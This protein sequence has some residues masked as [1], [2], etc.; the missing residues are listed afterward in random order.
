MW[1]ANILLKIFASIFLRDIGI[2]LLL[3]FEIG[4][5]KQRFEWGFDR[6]NNVSYEWAKLLGGP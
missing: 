1:L 5:T 3:N 6:S 2:L 4:Q